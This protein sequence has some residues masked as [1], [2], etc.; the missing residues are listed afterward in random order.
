LIAAA[1][2][3][4]DLSKILGVVGDM[5]DSSL[6]HI[7]GFPE[8]GAELSAL[9]ENYVGDDRSAITSFVDRLRKRSADGQSETQ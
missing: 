2:G 8:A 1:A 7:P 4:Y 9:A 3:T 6:Q 5:L